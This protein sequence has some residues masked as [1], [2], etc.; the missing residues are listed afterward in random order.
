MLTGLLKP[1]QILY[2]FQNYQDLQEEYDTKDIS[3]FICNTFDLTYKNPTDKGMLAQINVEVSATLSKMVGD[4]RQVNFERFGPRSKYSYRFKANP[5]VD[6]PNPIEI[7]VPNL[8]A[9]DIFT[10]QPKKQIIASVQEDIQEEVK[11]D[12]QQDI[13]A[14]FEDD[15]T[16]DIY[17]P[18]MQLID[19]VKKM[20]L[21]DFDNLQFTRKMQDKIITVNITN[22]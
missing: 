19:R 14:H 22:A 5:F 4:N 18:F 6:I 9:I 16:P 15:E 1:Q 20:N 12:V 7:D 17:D 2:F 10:K 3:I 21:Y 11:E 13:Q 8:Y